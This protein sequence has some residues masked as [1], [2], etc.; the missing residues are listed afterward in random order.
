VFAVGA[1]D[2]AF[3]KLLWPLVCLSLPVADN[4]RLCCALSGCMRCRLLLSLCA[5][6]VRQSVSLSLCHAAQLGCAYGVKV[7]VKVRI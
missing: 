6:S 5:V 7:K 4:D 2:A 3:A 1:F